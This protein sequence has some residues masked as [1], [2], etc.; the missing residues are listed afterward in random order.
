[1]N[2][3]NQLTVL[4]MVLIPVFLILLLV[5]M[6]HAE[7]MVGD[8]QF[9]VARLIAA[10]VF[11][12]ASL[13]DFLD[14]YLARRLHLVSNFGKFM[15]PLA[16]KLLTMA[17]FVALVGLREMPSWMVIVILAREFAITG[18]R[19]V[20]VEQGQVIAASPIAKWKTTFQML[21][22]ILY[23]LNNIPFGT[24]GFPLAYICLWVAVILT[25]LS[26]WDYFAKNKHV[27]RNSN[28]K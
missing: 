11:I 7:L 28:L 20:A 5:P 18:F 10:I 23:L 17:A 26:G 16:D 13:T 8:A 14:G 3:A 12:V 24:N 4:R 9:T 6:G 27:L 2:I 19:L 15:D 1:M 25:I 22:L 21:A